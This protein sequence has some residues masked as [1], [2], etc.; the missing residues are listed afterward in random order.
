VSDWL[1]R[2]VGGLQRAEPGWR[3]I[4]VAPQ[5]GGGLT[6]ARVVH[7]TVRGRAEVAWRIESGEMRVDVV[8]PAGTTAE[9]DLPGHPLGTIVRVGAGAH[10][11]RYALPAGWGRPP[12]PGLDTPLMELVRD[13]RVW[14]PVLEVLRSYLPGVPI[15]AG[16]QLSPDPLRALIGQLPGAADDLERDL[17]QALDLALDGR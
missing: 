7:D 15:E 4:R 2:V 12:R 16:A 5:P 6:S 9:V 1:H 14:P 10:T 3:R 17:R 13:P 11:W 8:V